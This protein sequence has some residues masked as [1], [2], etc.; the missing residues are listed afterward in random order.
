VNVVVETQLPDPAW[1]AA[2]PSGHFVQP[3]E[4]TCPAVDLPASH[5]AHAAASPPEN[6]PASHPVQL[7]WAADA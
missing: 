2:V 5:A 1:G 6:R 4:F 7:P 3:V